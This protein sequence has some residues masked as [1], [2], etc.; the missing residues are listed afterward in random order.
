MGNID[1]WRPIA[2]Q[3]SDD[4]FCILVDLPGHGRS[5]NLAD[6]DYQF[7]RCAKNLIHLLDEL[8]IDQTNLIG[9][10]MGGR[11]GLYMALTY[12]DRL[13]KVILESA[14]V[15][16]EDLSGKKERV[17]WDKELAAKLESMSFSD[18]NKE[19]YAMPM[20]GKLRE[21]P[22]FE[23]VLNDLFFK[24]SQK[25]IHHFCSFVEPKLGV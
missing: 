13:A 21:H 15:G 16:I 3:L 14:G 18:F 12:P 19:W 20:F 6:Q 25:W 1:T 7:T 2:N 5:V 9:Y 8:K 22:E 23:S 10:S 4:Y 17:E 11:I 24:V